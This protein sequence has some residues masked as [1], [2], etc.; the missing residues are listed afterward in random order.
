VDNPISHDLPNIN[1][2]ITWAM[3]AGD[4]ERALGMALS[5][6]KFWLLPA[7]PA[8]TVRLA[9]LEAAV[10]LPWSPSNSV[11]IRT[12]GRAYLSAGLLKTRADP[13]GA[14]RLLEQGRILF[15]RI[16]DKAGVSNCVR[17][18]G[19]ASVVG[20]DPEKGRRE[21]AESLFLSRACGDALGAAWS[22][23]LLGIA[24]FVSGDYTEASSYFAPERHRV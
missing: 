11:G 1:A 12:R 8:P 7:A 19:A 23:N 15:E 21:I 22:R 2:A 9:W 24:A 3:D 6:G 10:A 5:I 4:A 17:H 16:G 13:V 18:R 14:L 20:G